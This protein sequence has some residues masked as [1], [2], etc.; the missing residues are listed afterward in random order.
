MAGKQ[1]LLLNDVRKYYPIFKGP[2][3][4]VVGNVKAVDGVYLSISRGETVGFVGESGCGKTTLGKCIVGLHG[5]TGGNIYYDFGGEELTD[6]NDLDKQGKFNAKKKIQM[7]FQDPYSSLNP[8]K[9]I[10]EAF[11]EPMRVHRLGTK[12]QRK[13][14]IAALLETVS[15]PADYMYRF[16]HE[17]SGGQ[18][19]RICIARALCVDPEMI[20]CDEPVSALDVSI[21]AQVLNLMKDLQERKNL[22]YIFIAHDLSVV[23]YMSDRVAVMYLGRVV[24]YAR[25]DALYDNP[26]HPYTQALLSAVPVPDIDVK[27]ERII[28][29]GDVPSPAHPPSGCRFHP[30]CSKCQDICRKT[31]PFL[32]NLDGNED[33]QVACHF[34]DHHA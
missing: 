13:E 33:H 18:R 23:Q 4:R 28:L 1:I 31:E 12:A 32:E 34:P 20:V 11:D 29:E 26:A 21:Q 9:N 3:K 7:V 24:E 10:Y 25:S 16:P 17:F 27:R 15:L 2:L 14:K 6:L 8:V 22:T 30:R 5:I 19:Q